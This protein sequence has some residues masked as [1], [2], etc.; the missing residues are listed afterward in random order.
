MKKRGIIYK[1][2][3]P[4]GKVYIGQTVD[5]KGRKNGHR[6]A[7]WKYNSHFYSAIKKY[8]WNSFLYEVIFE[9][10][11]EDSKKLAIILDSMERHYIKKYDSY[12]NGYNSTPGGKSFKERK[13]HSK[14]NKIAQF[15]SNGELIATWPSAKEIERSLNI[16]SIKITQS[17][18]G[19]RGLVGGYNWKLI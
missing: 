14:I 3:S 13:T 5:E 15:S 18:K 17:C 11:S 2:T 1:Y 8:G 12:K 9:C 7:C 4:S 16:S 6:S 19:L 10:K